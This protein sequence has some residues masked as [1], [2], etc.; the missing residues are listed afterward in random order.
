MRVDPA[1]S[2]SE[3]LPAEAFGHSVPASLSAALRTD[4]ES[5]VAPGSPEEVAALL[6]WASKTAVGVVPVGTGAHTYPRYPS[7]PFV[8]LTTSRLTEIGHYEPADLTLTASAGARVGD[9]STAMAVHGQWLPFDP[10]DVPNRTLGG[11]V[12][13]GLSGPLW[14]GYGQLRNHVLGATVVCGD[15]RVLKLGGRVV[16]NVAGF[17]ILKPMVGSRGDLAVITSLT[18]RLFPLPAVDRLLIV[19]ASDISELVSTARAIATAPVMPAS[20]VLSSTS[21]GGRLLVRLHGVSDSVGADQRRLEEHTSVSFD[22]RNVYELGDLLEG[23]RDRDITGEFAVRLWALPSRID[24][25]LVAVGQIPGVNLTADVYGGSVRV[26]LPDNLSDIKSVLMRLREDV[27]NLGGTIRAL[28]VPAEVDAF[29]YF[30][31]PLVDEREL[32][33]GLKQV[34]DPHGVLWRVE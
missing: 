18:V 20:I 1:D 29:S 16:K 9:L 21:V 2:L 30:T 4:V 7:D 24:E 27:E 17:D 32:A 6:R 31:K 34:F 5:V 13:A 33:T 22:I 3:I 12:A 15:G 8:V 10:P 28:R 26:Y 23:E 25:L 19:E 14:A 11:L